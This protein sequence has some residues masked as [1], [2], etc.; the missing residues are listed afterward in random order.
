MHA[1]AFASMEATSSVL[2]SPRQR[3]CHAAVAKHVRSTI[4]PFNNAS[5]STIYTTVFF[6]FFCFFLQCCCVGPCPLRAAGIRKDHC[7]PNF[8][9]S[10]AICICVTSIFRP[11][12]SVFRLPNNVRKRAMA[13]RL[14]V[15]SAA[16]TVSTSRR[17]HPRLPTS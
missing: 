17:R 16:W 10:A 2:L 11:F 9:C 7:S 6:F 12:L 3:C 14:L 15:A 13:K 8:E 5:R 1:K 4:V